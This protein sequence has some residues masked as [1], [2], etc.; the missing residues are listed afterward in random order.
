MISS[1]GSDADWLID[2]MSFGEWIECAS[3]DQ[4]AQILATVELVLSQT[5]FSHFSNMAIH[6]CSWRWVIASTV[7]VAV[8]S[9]HFVWSTNLEGPKPLA[10]KWTGL[11]C[12]ILSE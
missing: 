6:H 10:D 8:V 4:F 7:G 5:V 3:L 12:E 2:L 11:F 9:S 1:R